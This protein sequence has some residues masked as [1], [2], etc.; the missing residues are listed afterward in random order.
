MRPALTGTLLEEAGWVVVITEATGV[1]GAC[2]KT[3][4]CVGDSE[5]L[6]RQSGAGR[7]AVTREL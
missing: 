5:K 7:E 2:R 1:Q 4:H 6:N 3:C